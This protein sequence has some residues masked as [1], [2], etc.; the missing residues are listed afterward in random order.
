MRHTEKKMHLLQ[1]LG[2]QMKAQRLT[3]YQES[4]DQFAE[5]L[6]IFGAETNADDVAEMERGNPDIPI[7][8]WMSAFILM[9]VSDAVVKAS[10]SDAVLYLAAAKHAPGI[11]EEMKNALNKGSQ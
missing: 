4:P 10:K 2:E 7:G 1:K 9:Q 5:R 3:V 8:T 11:E 6:K